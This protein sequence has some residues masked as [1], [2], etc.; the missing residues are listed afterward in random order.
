MK[1]F[2]MIVLAAA[3]LAGSA[4]AVA[5]DQPPNSAPKPASFVPHSH[6]SHHVYGSPIGRPIVGHAKTSHHQHATK[7]SPR[8][9]G[10]RAQG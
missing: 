10:R 6:S 8:A 4:L 2:A 9:G 7:K 3:T 5:G 1:T